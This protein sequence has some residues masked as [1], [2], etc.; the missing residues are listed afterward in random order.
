MLRYKIQLQDRPLGAFAGPAI[1]GS[2]GTLHAYPAGTQARVAMYDKDGT[3]ITN[4]FSLVRG[5]AEFYVANTAANEALDI[6][7]MTGEG[8]SAQLWSVGPDEVHEVPIDRSAS[9]QMLVLP[10]SIADVVTDAVA[11]NTG[12][13]LVVGQVFQPWPHMK[14]VT[15]DAGITADAGIV[16]TTTGFISALTLT[17]TG[18][19]KDADG[20][21][22]TAIVTYIATA[23]NLTWTI[24]A[25]GDTGTGYIFL[26][27]M[28]MRTG[29]P[30][31]TQA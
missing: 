24:S 10:F 7:V 20:S 14:V 11:V 12:L 13:T 21:L 27:Y 2:G 28:M 3:A 16:G 15:T 25:G 19:V 9:H 6:F 5:S 30:I 8:Y 23:V 31:I 22:I 18:L 26:P 4:P 1:I 29:A 17:G